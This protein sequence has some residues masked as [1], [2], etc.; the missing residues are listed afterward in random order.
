MTGNDRTRLERGSLT[1]V[2]DSVLDALVRALHPDEAERDHLHDLARQANTSPRARA[3]RRRTTADVR[4]AGRTTTPF[5]AAT[6]QSR[7]AC[8]PSLK[9][10]CAPS[11]PHEA[12]PIEEMTS[13]RHHHRC[14]EAVWLGPLIKLAGS[15]R[16]SG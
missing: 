2:S 5:D 9:W 16:R 1:G 13:D 10:P 7:S 11:P 3:T 12:A 14:R 15:G 4:P 6:R 8:R